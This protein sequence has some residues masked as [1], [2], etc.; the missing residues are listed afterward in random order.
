[1]VDAV[2]LYV[3]AVK[4][5]V[6]FAVPEPI[7]NVLLMLVSCILLLLTPA[8]TPLTPALFIEFA[9]SVIYKATFTVVV[10][11]LAGTIPDVKPITLLAVPVPITSVALLQLITLFGRNRAIKEKER[12]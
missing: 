7:T 10:E 3:C 9:I 5:N 1:M 12:G 8:V 11:V 2:A 6:L 4:P